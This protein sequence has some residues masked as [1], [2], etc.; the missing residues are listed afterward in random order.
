MNQCKSDSGNGQGMRIEEGPMLIGSL[1]KVNKVIAVMSGKGGVGKSSVSSILAANLSQNGYQVG[2]L[3]ADITGPSIAKA[4]GVKAGTC[5]ASEYGLNP[6]LSKGGIKI[7]SINLLLENEDDPVVWRGPLIAGAIKQFWEETNWGHLDYL[8]VDLPPGTGDA[9]LTVLQSLPVSGVVIVS[10]PQDLS[11][12]V[13]KK[14][15]KMVHKM[16]INIFGLIENMSYVECPD[17][18]KRIELFCNSSGQEVSAQ[19]AIPFLGSIPWDNQI[20][21]LMDAGEIEFYER[22]SRLE[23]I[24]KIVDNI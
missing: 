11:L 7:L 10:S 14:A 21:K 1:N 24:N 19:M 8:V 4:F 18:G 3:D 9:A 6:P 15:I 17:C 22:I 12:M 23:A 16:N 5:T 13:V 20:N 2:V